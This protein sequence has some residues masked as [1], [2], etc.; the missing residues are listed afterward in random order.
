MSILAFNLLI[1]EYPL[2]EEFISMLKED[3]YIFNGWV[4]NYVGIS[5]FL[6]GLRD[7]VEIIKPEGLKNYLNLK[8]LNKKF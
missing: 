2:S 1:E 8:I 7:E 5:R 3:S 6:L 4:S